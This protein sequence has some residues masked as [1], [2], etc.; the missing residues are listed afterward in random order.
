MIGWR[1]NTVILIPVIKFYSFW[2]KS[3]NLGT[4]Q[5]FFII[6][7]MKT[8][9]FKYDYSF[10]HPASSY[11][12]NIIQYLYVIKFC[13]K[14][15]AFLWC[16]R[17]CTYAQIISTLCGLG[18]QMYMFCTKEYLCNVV[19]FIIFAAR[20]HLQWKKKPKYI[21]PHVFR[22]PYVFCLTPELYALVHMKTLNYILRLLNYVQIFSLCIYRCCKSSIKQTSKTQPSCWGKVLP[23]Q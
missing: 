4:L 11:F 13:F 19:H 21:R 15:T 10:Q 14:L 23:S 2:S 8:L 5:Q 12:T 7:L 20:S 18:V 16:L 6:L 3:E 22:R 9:F 17:H 1:L